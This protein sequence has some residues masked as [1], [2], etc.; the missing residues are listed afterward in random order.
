MAQKRTPDLIPLCHPIPITKVDVDVALLPPNSS[1]PLVQKGID[2]NG[3]V[4]IEA[5]VECTGPTGVEMEAL[6]A[7]KHRCNDGL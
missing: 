6:A 5:L 7:G 2:E 1:H 3:A 4:A